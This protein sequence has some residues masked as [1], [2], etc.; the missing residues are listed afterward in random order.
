MQAIAAV[1]VGMKHTKRPEF[2][3]YQK[4]VC[5]GEITTKNDKLNC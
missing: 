4:Q 1:A 5:V 2:V 3:E